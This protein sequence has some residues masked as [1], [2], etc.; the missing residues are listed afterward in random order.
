MGRASSVIPNWYYWPE[1]YCW[2]NFEDRTYWDGTVITI[3]RTSPTPNRS[4]TLCGKYKIIKCKVMS[5]NADEIWEDE[6][7]DRWIDAQSLYRI[8]MSLSKLSREEE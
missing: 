7:P 8:R 6:D 2:V 5:L 3:V 4:R 1:M